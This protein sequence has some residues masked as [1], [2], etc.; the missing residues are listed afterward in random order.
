M[1]IKLLGLHHLD[2]DDPKY[3]AYWQKVGDYSFQFTPNKENASDL[4]QK[5]V[6][7]ILKYKKHYCRMYGASEMIVVKEV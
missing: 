5:E 3:S 2:K 1:F 6:D 4:T 7:N